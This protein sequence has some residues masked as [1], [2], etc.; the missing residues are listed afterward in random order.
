M[1]GNAVPVLI[2]LANNLMRHPIELIQGL[3]RVLA[4]LSEAFTLILISKDGG[5]RY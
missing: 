3:A 2:G 5:A 1:S 4:D